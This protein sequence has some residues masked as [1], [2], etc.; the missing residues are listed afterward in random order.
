VV[1]VVSAHDGDRLVLELVG[2][3]LILLEVDGGT[4]ELLEGTIGTKVGRDGIAA[5]GDLLLQNK[6]MPD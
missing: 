2:G 6:S 1:T 4:S 5:D 3:S